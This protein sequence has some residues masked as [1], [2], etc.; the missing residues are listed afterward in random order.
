MISLSGTLLCCRGAKQCLV[1][2]V[3]AK[4]R[5]H[6]VLRAW[7]SNCEISLSITNKPSGFLCRRIKSKHTRS[8]VH[9]THFGRGLSHQ[10]EQPQ[11]AGLAIPTIEVPWRTVSYAC[12]LGFVFRSDL[13]FLYCRT[14]RV[15][16]TSSELL[17][18]SAREMS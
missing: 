14:C 8:G 2:G 12:P 10:F 9:L 5:G 3:S 15:L 4:V 6:L 18:R 16:R 11:G 13:T 1:K 7:R 17:C